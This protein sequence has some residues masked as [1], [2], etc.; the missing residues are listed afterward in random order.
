M[1]SQNSSQRQ[2]GYWSQNNEFSYSHINNN[3]IN[4]EPTIKVEAI[5]PINRASD[6]ANDFLST[7]TLSTDFYIKTEE[8]ADQMDEIA[9]SLNSFICQLVKGKLPGIG[10]S[11]LSFSRSPRSPGHEFSEVDCDDDDSYNFLSV[12]NESVD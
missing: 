3:E 5:E 9:S 11:L 10:Y 7:L 1:D 2:D 8:N 6:L 12:K 4:N